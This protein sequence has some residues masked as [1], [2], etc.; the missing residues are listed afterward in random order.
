MAKESIITRSFK[1]WKI[2]LAISIGIGVAVWML[3]VSISAVHF[4]KVEENVGNYIWKDVNNNG[5]VDTHLTE[6]FVCV[7]QGNY[8]QQTASDALTHIHW[9]NKSILWIV[10]ALLFMVG[11]DFFYMLRIRLLTHYELSWKSSFYVIMIWEF[12]SALAP[13][14]IGGAAVA[15]FILNKEK[16]DLGRSTAI[17]FITALMDNLFYILLIPFVFVF[18]DAIQLFPHQDF[19]SSSVQWIFWIGYSVFVGICLFM[20]TTLFLVP[21]LATG[22]LKIVFS[23]PFLNRKKE[24]AIKTGK[25]IEASSKIFKKE[26]FGFWL[27]VFGAT[28]GSWISR[29]LVINALLQAFLNL[30]I[31]DHLLI[32]GKQLILWLLMRV[33]PTPGG[34][35]IAEYAFGELMVTFSQSALLLAA[36]AILWR[37]ISYFPYLFIGAV[38]LPRWLRRK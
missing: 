15:M 34:S 6:E 17:I 35:G 29:F 28:C 33:S 21:K 20:F 25:D 16:I 36:L 23:L 9:T 37:L 10:I 27:K 22:F 18:I 7:S 30:G 32:L 19:N 31:M 5:L 2:W 8:R 14:V 24:Y 12:A 38:L 26:S 13:G 3:Y 4:I 1:G 11:R